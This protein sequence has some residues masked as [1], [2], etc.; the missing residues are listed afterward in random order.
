MQLSQT[1][2]GGLDFVKPRPAQ[3]PPQLSA[4]F[5]SPPSPCV[6]ARAAEEE[7]YA[8]DDRSTLHQLRLSDA[9]RIAQKLV[10]GAAMTDSDAIGPRTLAQPVA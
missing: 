7:L 3:P 4:P 8:P 10:A 2:S 6:A 9:R 5:Q 1:P